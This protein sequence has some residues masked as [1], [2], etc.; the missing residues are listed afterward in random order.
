MKQIAREEALSSLSDKVLM[1]P[2][3]RRGE[4]SPV[5]GQAIGYLRC[6]EIIEAGSGL[7]KFRVVRTHSPG[8]TRGGLGE[9]R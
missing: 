3:E 7:R 6:E 2:Y 5:G 4:F 9:L 8:N 1:V